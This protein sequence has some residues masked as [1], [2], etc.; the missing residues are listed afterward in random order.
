MKTVILIRH[1]KS[2]WDDP[3]MSDF[4]R[5][6]NDRGKKDA[7]EM[8]ARLLKRKQKLDA[9]ISSPAKRAKKTAAIFAKEYGIDKDEL[10]LVDKLYHASERDFL[11]V[12]SQLPET[13]ENIAVFSHNPGLTDFVNTL[14]DKIRTDNVPTC[15]MFAVSFEGN[16]QMF[17]DAP[18]EFLFFDYPKNLFD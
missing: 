7:P 4:D 3:S 10:V 15:G 17:K 13:L 16:W 2:S 11:E 18:K 9:F 8:A 12:I 14:T 6:L 5:P 1:A